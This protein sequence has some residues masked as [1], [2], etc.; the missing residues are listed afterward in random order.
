MS[1]YYGNRF[2]ISLNSSFFN[3]SL[4]LIQEIIRLYTPPIPIL[5][6]TVLLHALL[7]EI[8]PIYGS[9]VNNLEK[10]DTRSNETPTILIL[11]NIRKTY[12]TSLPFDDIE[13]FSIG[14]V[15]T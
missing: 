3:S 7:N 11:G 6:D 10:E 13:Y 14:C 9:L 15:A 12:V 4:T 5:L 1:S 2:S 8:I